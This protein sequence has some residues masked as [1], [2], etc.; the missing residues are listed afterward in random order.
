MP[1]LER[2]LI[3]LALGLCYQNFFTSYTMLQKL[4]YTDMEPVPVADTQLLLT[5]C[6]QYLK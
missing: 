2:L 1:V 5:F 6:W 3:R 4:S